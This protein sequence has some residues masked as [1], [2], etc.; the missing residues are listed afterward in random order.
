MKAIFVISMS[1]LR[2]VRLEAFTI[3]ST[4]QSL[5]RVRNLSFIHKASSTDINDGDN[6]TTRKS[7][8]GIIYNS[9]SDP[10]KDPT[11]QL[12]TKEGCTLCDKVVDVL[13]SIQSTQPHSLHAIDITDPDHAE[14]YDKYK[15]DIPIL[16]VNGLYWIKHRITEGEAI[17]GLSMVQSGEFVASD[18]EPDA[19]AMERRQAER[20]AKQD[21]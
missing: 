13:K 11:V 9:N 16:H 10:S 2:A 12:F 8:T 4:L 5:H 17:Q 15:W 6:T 14:Y 20:N 3:R 18:G 21:S 1:L 7:V 19:A